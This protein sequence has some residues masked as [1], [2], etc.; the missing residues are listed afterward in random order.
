MTRDIHV[1]GPRDGDGLDS[2]SE[3]DIYAALWATAPLPRLP[4]DAPDRLKDFAVDLDV[5]DS[6]RI[7]TIYRAARRHLFQVLVER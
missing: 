3:D 5:D 4:E 2:T 1:H 6:R 7:Y